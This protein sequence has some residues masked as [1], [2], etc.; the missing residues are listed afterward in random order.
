MCREGS[1]FLCSFGVEFCDKSD[2]M[3][4]L[5]SHIRLKC[6]S[7]PGEMA[8]CVK[9]I[10]ATSDNLSLSPGRKELS[11]YPCA[12]MYNKAVHSHVKI[13]FQVEIH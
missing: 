3:L 1:I 5:F 8:Q 4:L 13:M 11:L 9:A 2:L 6:Y 7:W 10:S 12:M